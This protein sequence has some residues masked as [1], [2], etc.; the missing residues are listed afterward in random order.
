MLTY[1]CAVNE[2]ETDTAHLVQLFDSERSIVEGVARFVEQGLAQREQILLVMSE[3]RWNAVTMRLSALGSRI[4][5]AVRF[6]HVVVRIAHDQLSKF[7]RGDRPDR[8]LFEATV[9]TLVRGQAAFHRRLRI[10]GEMVDMLA[11][12]GQYKAALELEKLWNDLAK[13]HRFTLLC[14]YTSGHFGDPHNADDLRRIC[15]A[16]STVAVDREDVLA[17]FLVNQLDAVPATSS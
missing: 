8:G 9:G 3:E 7:M 1:P 15:Q 12:Q 17:S 14:G 11:A 4:D 6:G 5:E 2:K 16:H 13:R 10:Y